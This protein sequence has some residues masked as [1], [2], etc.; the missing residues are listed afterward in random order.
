MHNIRVLTKGKNRCTLQLH[1]DDAER[2][3]ILD[4]AMAAGSRR[5]SVR[6]R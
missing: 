2:L 5:G 4:G 6:C 1:P 3:G